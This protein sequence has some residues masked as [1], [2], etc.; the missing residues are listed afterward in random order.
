MWRPR[1]DPSAGPKYK[2]IVQAITSD[3]E[4][5]TLRPGQQLPT[6]RELS[7]MLGTSIATITKA[8]TEAERQQLVYGQ[9]GRGTFV[10]SLGQKKAKTG[11]LPPQVDQSLVDFSL[12]VS[13]PL[14]DFASA[15]ALSTGIKQ[16]GSNLNLVDMMGYQNHEGLSRHRKAA[17]KWLAMSG[18][19]TEPSD[20]LLTASAQ[21]AFQMV[22]SVLCKPGDV[23]LTAELTHPGIRD[24]AHL[25]HL[26]LHGLAMDEE[27][28]LP[29][30][31]EEAARA[32]LS[33]VLYVMP[34][35]QNPTVSTMSV[36]RRL[37]IA[38]IA[39]RFNIRI[40][41]DGVHNL[42]MKKRLHPMNVYAPERTFYVTSFSKTLTPGLR[43]GIL[44]AP[45]EYH[46]DLRQAIRAT[47]W[48]TSPLL[49]EM[50]TLWIGDGTAQTMLRNRQ[51]ESLLRLNIAKNTLRNIPFRAQNGGFH[52]WIPLPNGIDENA[53]VNRL[54]SS[55]VAVNAGGVFKTPNASTGYPAIRVCLSGPKSAAD[56]QDGLVILR[57]HLKA[58]A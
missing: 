27:G 37:D 2:A 16:V 30:A 58:I 47:M 9:V 6:H 50:M 29:E 41:E 26:K 1:L 8:I 3:I 44:R 18:L 21:H 31:F 49:G 28:I 32:G 35:L 15:R 54:K 55:G 4:N 34:S 25:L 45:S 38:A 48:M 42:L 5:G 22:L 33:N 17:V 39:K 11:D 51:D 14:A 24:L 40:I 53:F 10:R 57:N 43:V 7:R 52:I 20:L 12:L 46:K 13:P 23:V 56:V 19:E 36:N